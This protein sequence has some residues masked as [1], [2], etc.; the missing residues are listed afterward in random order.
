[1]IR[2]FQIWG[3]SLFRGVQYDEKRKRHIITPRPPVDCAATSIGLPL[4]N[5]ARMGNTALKGYQ[6]LISSEPEQLKDQIVLLEFGG[7]DC[8]FDWQAV[9]KAPSQEHYCH[10]PP[11]LYR[12][13]MK[14]MIDAVISA[15]SI[16]VMTTLP[17]LN[18]DN[19][20]RWITLGGIEGDNIL[21]F[22]G[23]VQQIYRWQE[24]YSQMNMQIAHEQG[25]YC[26]PIREQF[27]SSTLRR[28]WLCEDGI[29]PNEYGYHLIYEVLLSQWEQ[30]AHRLG[31]AT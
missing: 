5:H 13:T 9:A 27:L 23:D 14:K 6:C 30:N 10:V 20:F 18:A 24:Y 26:L 31:F 21:A 15:G 12:D 19:F 4:I 28:E 17:P 3:D 7:N 11:P 29:H 25:V 1:M 8:D 2:G 22:L 16:P